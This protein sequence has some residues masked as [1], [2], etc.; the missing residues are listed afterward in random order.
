MRAWKAFLHY[1]IHSDRKDFVLKKGRPGDVEIIN[2]LVTLVDAVCIKFEPIALTGSTVPAWVN[3]N[4]DM[5]MMQAIFD[6]L[7]DKGLRPKEYASQGV[8]DKMAAH[9]QDMRKIAFKRLGIE[10]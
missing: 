4:V 9:L 7:W 8:I 10:P 3:E 6:E 2:G 5:D 1:N